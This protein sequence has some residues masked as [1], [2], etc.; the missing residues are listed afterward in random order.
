ME[1]EL[2]S[3]KNNVYKINIK[4]ISEMILFQIESKDIPKKLIKKGFSYE[5]MRKDFNFFNKEELENVED[6]YGE[7]KS[8]IEQYNKSQSSQL[9]CKLK[10][11]DN[12]I[13]F[14]I[15]PTFL[16]IKYIDILFQQKIDVDKTLYELTSIYKKLKQE[17]DNE[18]NEREKK[19][20]NLKEEIDELKNE[21]NYLKEA[22]KKEIINL[23]KEHN[24]EINELKNEIKNLKEENKKEINELKNGLKYFLYSNSLL[25]IY[26]FVFLLFNSF[27]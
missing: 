19:Y 14:I 3:D 16:K 9:E 1:L 7:L 6:I 2:T 25:F 18:I 12:K 17:K 27:K 5:D 15:K 10:E 20:N 13:E 11:D 4:K 22:H 26:N 8:L 21:M 23:N 24:E